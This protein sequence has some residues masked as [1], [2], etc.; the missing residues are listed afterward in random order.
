MLVTTRGKHW[1]CITMQNSS[2]DLWQHTRELHSHE[3]PWP[4][5]TR[6]SGHRWGLPLPNRSQKASHWSPVSTT[7][8]W[9]NYPSSTQEKGKN[10]YPNS[11]KKNF[12]KLFFVGH[13]ASNKMLEA[14]KSR[15]MTCDLASWRKLSPL[16]ALMATFILTA[17]ESGCGPPVKQNIVARIRRKVLKATATTF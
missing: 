6:E 4:E 7:W 8:N 5:L 16:A 3:C 17:H 14:L 15:Y 13:T 1:L 9:C 2:T 10:S 12:N 11:T